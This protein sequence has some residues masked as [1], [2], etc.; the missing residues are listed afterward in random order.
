MKINVTCENKPWI[1]L[2]EI[3]P[4]VRLD[5]GVS[6]EFRVC[7]F[8]SDIQVD[9]VKVLMVGTD[10]ENWTYDLPYVATFICANLG[11][12]E[13]VSVEEE[14]IQDGYNG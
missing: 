11:L 10:Y 1:N 7:L 12:V 2:I 13:V 14:I 3:D 8:N 4:Y 6:A 9:V 5:F